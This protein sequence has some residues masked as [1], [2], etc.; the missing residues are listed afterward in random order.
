M[1]PTGTHS[2]ATTGKPLWVYKR[3]FA[4]GV[5][6]ECWVLVESRM[7]GLASRLI[8]DGDEVA[9]DRTPASGPDAVRN[10][11]LA[12]RLP[13][14]RALE[15]EAGYINWYNI[16]IAVRVDGALVHES[17]PGKAIAFPARLART[18]TQQR[19]DGQP[20][21]D[22]DK[23]K[24][25]KVPIAVDIATGILFFLVAKFTDL[26]TAALVGAAVGIALLVVQRFVKV[27]LVGGMALFGI[28]MLLVSAGF[29]IAFEDEAVIKQRSTIVGLI[30][31]A[32]FLFD[33]LVLKGRKLGA[34]LNR[35]MAFADIDERRLA[36]GMGLVGLVMAGGNSLVAW[37]FST[38][39]W[40]V[41]TTF[42][43]IPV[44]MVLVLWAI[45]WSRA[46]A[47]VAAAR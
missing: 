27:D 11:R 34:G 38:D 16:G 6:H 18:M 24:R 19:G 3:R 31:A 45:G 40:L 43:D 46:P 29:A 33:G 32:C 26:K 41:Y 14:G 8:V 36:I 22:P 12:H 4:L 42:L 28:V 23:L 44:S 47:R 10:H 5:I 35:Y 13:D 21:Y 15:V 20:A 39:F 2:P 25:N 30:G 17:H 9:H 37:A 7:S 1:D